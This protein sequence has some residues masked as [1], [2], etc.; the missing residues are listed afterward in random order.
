MNM[1]EYESI[2]MNMNQFGWIWIS[3]NEFESK[4]IWIWTCTKKYVNAC[5]KTKYELIE[6]NDYSWICMNL[7]EYE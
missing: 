7:H 1:N 4:W 5:E 2:W 3:T 6:K